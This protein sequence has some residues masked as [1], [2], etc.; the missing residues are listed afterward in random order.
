MA[1]EKRLYGPAYLSSTYT[2]NVY[3]GAG[4]S[5]LLYDSVTGIEVCNTDTSQRTFRLYL[6][7]T[8]SNTGG[9][10]KFFD[11]PI[12]AGQTLMFPYPGRGMRL[13]STDFLVGGASVASK[14]TI[15]IHGTRNAAG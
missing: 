8:G 2:T 12:G 5:A 15:T 13:D 11:Y 9:T 3:Q 10:E 1:A 7:A 14:V 4:G 6:G